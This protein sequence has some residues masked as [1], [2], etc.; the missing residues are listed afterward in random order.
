MKQLVSRL[1]KIRHG[2]NAITPI[3]LAILIL[4]PTLHAEPTG[5]TISHIPPQPQYLPHP[6]R[7]LELTANLEGSKDTHLPL[8]LVAI[9]DGRLLDT[10]A[11]ESVWNY[12]DKPTYTF[13]LPAPQEEI[14]YQ[15]IL[16][17]DQKPLTISP[18]F[19]VRRNC[20]PDLEVVKAGVDEEKPLG[21]QTLQLFEITQKLDHELAAYEKSYELLE[22]I[23]QLLKK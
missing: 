11:V 10:V 21:A 1:K 19:R 2:F 20:K 14:S 16:L 5:I 18:R 4:T 23:E 13:Q 17:Q 3:L 15:F 7:T 22:E 12:Q 8:R 9:L 6:S